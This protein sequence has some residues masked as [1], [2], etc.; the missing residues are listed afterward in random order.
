MPQRRLMA[1]PRHVLMLTPECVCSTQCAVLK[2]PRAAEIR[3]KDGDMVVELTSRRRPPSSRSH[4][5]SKVLRSLLLT[6][7][8]MKTKA[9]A[10]DV[11]VGE[12][13]PGTTVFGLAVH[14][15]TCHTLCSETHL[16]SSCSPVS[17]A[18]WSRA[19]PQV[20]RQ[21]RREGSHPSSAVHVA[22]NHPALASAR[23]NCKHAHSTRLHCR[24]TLFCGCS[25][26]SALKMAAVESN[27]AF[28]ARL[29]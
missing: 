28:A 15:W 17:R 8:S 23:S 7:P 10:G 9:V 4:R 11:V 25:A 27:Q 12:V 22:A 20:V 14:S 26:R 1:A 29:S 21:Q 16:A 13:A 19:A 18:S 3:A 2:S 24:G 5:S 6:G